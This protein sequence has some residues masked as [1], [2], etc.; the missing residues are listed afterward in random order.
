MVKISSYD[1]GRVAVAKVKE[2]PTLP[3]IMS[4]IVEMTEDPRT[5]ST[6]LASFLSHDQALT[7]R[8]LKLANSAYYGLSNYISTVEMAV[9]VLGFE[10]IKKM[11]LTAKVFEALDSEE[12]KDLMDMNKFWIHSVVVAVACKFISKKLKLK[13][14]EDLFVAGLLHDI[15]ALAMVCY[16]TEDYFIVLNHLKN[17]NKHTFE[18]ETDLLGYSHADLGGLLTGKWN[19]SNKIANCISN[20]HTPWLSIS[21]PN[22]A[23]IVNFADVLAWESD[24][25]SIDNAKKPILCQEV[26]DYIKPKMKSESTIDWD[27]YHKKLSKEIMSGI[28]YISVLI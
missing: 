2:I 6:Q 15:G 7:V 10:E 13:S 4:R 16:Q 5:N 9:V 21:K 18:V 24:Y 11:V 20:H 8:I 3:A 25:P 12:A 17:T 1:P 19:L 23:M 22:Y 28:H 14:A 26:I 27:Y